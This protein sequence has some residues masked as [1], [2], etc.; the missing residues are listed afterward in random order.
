LQ[1]RGELQLL[2]SP[3]AL[4]A[5]CDHA[6]VGVT[7]LITIDDAGD[8]AELVRVNREF[9]APWDPVRDAEFFTVPVGDWRL[10]R[11]VRS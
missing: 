1:I 6:W 3:H 10:L 11:C 9:L 5:A 7:R 4:Y 2:T 8:L